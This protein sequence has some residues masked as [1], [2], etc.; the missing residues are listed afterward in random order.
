M[1]RINLLPAYIAEQRKVRAAIVAS[2][3][4]F[5]VV[6]GLGLG[7]VYGVLT[8]DIQRTKMA[9][10]DM[11]VKAEKEAATEAATAALLAQIKPLKDK[12]DFVELVQYHNIIRQKIFRQAARYTYRKVEYNAM[13]V[14]G[15]TLSISAN[16]SSLSDI[17]RFYILMFGNPDVTA[18][19][20]SGV[21][22]WATV[23]KT[24]PVIIPGGPPPAPPQYA[25]QMNATL[26]QG[27]VAPSLPATLLGGSVGGGGMPGYSGG[28]SMPGA[29]M[30]MGSGGP[31]PMGSGGPMP[32][33]TGSGRP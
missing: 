24:R 18:V 31:M 1:L 25:I 3:L 30:P 26:V 10:D 14:T 5:L 16:V 15:N 27:V 7:Y 11:R 33:A 2:A 23:Q 12:V 8:P 22:D 21:P 6:T 4:L 29:P 19:S 13:A 28:S 32:M 17:G 20:I 9:A